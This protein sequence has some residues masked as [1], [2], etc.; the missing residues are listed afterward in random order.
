MTYK[1]LEKLI[2]CVPTEVGIYKTQ[3]GY[4]VPKQHEGWQI[5]KDTKHWDA[6]MKWPRAESIKMI[7]LFE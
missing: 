1:G 7:F 5:Y 6:F 4:Y 2:Q 3:K